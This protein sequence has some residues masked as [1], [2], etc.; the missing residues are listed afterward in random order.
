ME[1]NI[2]LP[3][4]D[5]YPVP[6]SNCKGEVLWIPSFAVRRI[7]CRHCGNLEDFP[8]QLERLNEKAR[9]GCDSLSSENK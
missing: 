8:D 4:R 6:C 5:V 3:Q 1:I 2:K 7:T 9:E